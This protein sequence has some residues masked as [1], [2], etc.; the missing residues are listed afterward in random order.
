MSGGSRELEPAT[1]GDREYQA[2]E[3]RSQG[4]TAGVKTH[5]SQA[6]CWIT[7]PSK[8]SERSPSYLLQAHG[9]GRGGVNK[10]CGQ[11]QHTDT[12]GSCSVLP[13]A[14]TDARGAK[15]CQNRVDRGTDQRSP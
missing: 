11:L 3:S 6:P 2:T 7:T 14:A 12:L 9:V 10:E 4:V 5:G 15:H 1:A 8:Q 13:A